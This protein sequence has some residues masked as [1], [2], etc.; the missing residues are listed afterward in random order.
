MLKKS[1]TVYHAPKRR[2]RPYEELYIYYLKGRL[3]LENRI[4]QENF[5]GKWEEEDDSILF[6]SSAANRQIEKL[7]LRQPQLQF[8]DSYHMSYDHWLG[9][10][11]STFEHGK[12]RIIPPWEISAQSKGDFTDK[13]LILLDPGLV[14]GTGTHPTTRNCLEALELAARSKH[15]T[16]VIDLGTGTGLLALASARLG[17]KH[18]VGVDLNLLAAKTAQNNVRLNHLEDQVIIV[19]GRAEDMIAYPADLV[20]A[21][22]HYDV[23]QHL[24]A[25]KGFLAKRHFILSG[26]MRSEAKDITDKLTGQSV[27]LLKQWS[28]DGIWHTIYGKTDI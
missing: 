11:F 19:Q 3:K 28:H 9:E 1:N 8:V 16:T 20:I 18:A 27:E 25:A 6:F 13:L 5:I 15:F 26:L 14:F 24:I 17:C 4:F 10:A 21:N 12:F 22:I 23:M 2:Y 7:L